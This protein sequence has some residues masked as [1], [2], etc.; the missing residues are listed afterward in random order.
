[1]K[2]TVEW[3]EETDKAARLLAVL[4]INEGPYLVFVD[5]KQTC[6]KILT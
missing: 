1:V 5:S 2:Q 3:L 4:A 6:E